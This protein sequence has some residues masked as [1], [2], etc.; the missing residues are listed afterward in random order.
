M[1][2][3]G[4]KFIK[5]QELKLPDKALSASRNF[6][7]R[8][9][10]RSSNGYRFRSCSN[11]K[12]N[13]S[14][15]TQHSFG[16]VTCRDQWLCSYSE[17][18][19]DCALPV[20]LSLITLHGFTCSN[21]NICLRRQNSRFRNLVADASKG[22]LVSVDF[23][24]DKHSIGL[25]LFFNEISSKKIDFRILF[26]DFGAKRRIFFDGFW[27]FFNDFYRPRSGRFF[28]DDF[29]WRPKN[30]HGIWRFFVKNN[31]FRFFWKVFRQKI[32]NI[33]LFC[34]ISNIF[35]RFF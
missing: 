3:R 1:V 11:S 22:I 30:F 13:I 21:P 28:F 14:S 17:N 23:L 24:S 27:F 12:I 33:L 5:F 35:W 8:T 19:H 15:R 9:A 6:V 29:F 20:W 34:D 32:L 16:S 25:V 18:K 2:T 31:Y 4:S 10:W 7:P 26:D